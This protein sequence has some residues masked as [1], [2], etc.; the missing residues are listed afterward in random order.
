MYNVQCTMYNVQC[1]MYN[2]QCT[3]YNVQCTLQY[4]G[5]TPAIRLSTLQQDDGCGLSLNSKE[6]LMCYKHTQVLCM[7]CSP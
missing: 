3:M 7:Q 6:L 2:V 5:N 4:A 1:T